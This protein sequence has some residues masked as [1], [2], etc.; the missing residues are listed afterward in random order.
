LLDPSV[1]PVCPHGVRRKEKC[2][3]VHQTSK[4]A[5]KHVPL[6][7]V[8]AVKKRKSGSNFVRKGP[9]QRGYRQFIY[10]SDNMDK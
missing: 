4:R 5:D 7:R 9:L 8:G 1:I 6:R 2:G 3:I 10:K